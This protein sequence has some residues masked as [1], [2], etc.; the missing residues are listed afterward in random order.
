LVTRQLIHSPPENSGG[1]FVLEKE[2]GSNYSLDQVWRGWHVK[3]GRHKPKVE[4]PGAIY[5]VMSRANGNGN[6]FET[7]VDRADFLKNLAEACGKT[8]FQIP[9]CIRPRRRT[10]PPGCSYL[11]RSESMG[12]KWMPQPGCRVWLYDSAGLAWVFMLYLMRNGDH[13]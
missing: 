1:D 7:D 9:V 4:Y 12:F 6:R 13:A 3:G 11:V 8:G 2:K 10:G 5:Y